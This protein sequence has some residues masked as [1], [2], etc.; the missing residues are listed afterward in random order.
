MLWFRWFR[1]RIRGSC[2]GTWVA[3][4]ESWGGLALPAGIAVWIWSTSP[5]LH[6]CPF[7]S[8]SRDFSSWTTVMRPPSLVRRKEKASG[9]RKRAAKRR[10]REWN[11][12][13]K[14][15]QFVSSCSSDFLLGISGPRAKL[16]AL[17][18]LLACSPLRGRPISP[19]QRQWGRKKGA[20][21]RPPQRT[22]TRSR[23]LSLPGRLYS[24]EPLLRAQSRSSKGISQPTDPLS[25]PGAT[26]PSSRSLRSGPRLRGEPRAVPRAAVRAQGLGVDPLE[27]LQM[28]TRARAG[29]GRRVCGKPCASLDAPWTQPLAAPH[30]RLRR[31][32][33]QSW[34]AES[35]V[36]E[37]W[38][39]WLWGNCCGGSLGHCRMFR[40]I[41]AFYPLDARDTSHPLTEIKTIKKCL[42][43]LP[44]FCWGG[45]GELDWEP[46]I[47]AAQTLQGSPA[48]FSLNT[49]KN[50]NCD[51]CVTL[52]QG[53]FLLVRAGYK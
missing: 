18:C 52:F 23:P 48:L 22:D 10:T 35:K 19:K 16:R 11:A 40:G 28:P 33:I 41:S 25:C 12:E 21:D 15:S 14:V 37:C 45:S 51:I 3:P 20:W 7:P 44:N 5:T 50:V 49:H 26:G 8:S 42:Q 1:A 17:G 39:F 6:R 47:G 36:S 4:W 29:T 43:T 13:R 38:H 30:V 24:G 32:G 9:D 31:L 46:L 27:N 53:C 34:K 2:C